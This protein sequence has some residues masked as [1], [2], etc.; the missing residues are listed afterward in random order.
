MKT[1]DEMKRGREW[2]AMVRGHGDDKT[3]E[4]YLREKGFG[5]EEVKELL[6]AERLAARKELCPTPC[7]GKC[8]RDGA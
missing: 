4:A 1:E 5:D 6:E 7:E 2:L 3:K 8:G